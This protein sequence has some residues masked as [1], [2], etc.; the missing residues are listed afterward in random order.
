M[1]EE[2]IRP[3]HYDV[4]WGTRGNHDLKGRDN[5]ISVIDPTMSL[6]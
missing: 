5:L 4:N 3:W 1:I 2:C 6:L